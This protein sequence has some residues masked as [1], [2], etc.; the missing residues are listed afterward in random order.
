MKTGSTMTAGIALVCGPPPQRLASNPSFGIGV[1]APD[2]AD[3]ATVIIA[4]EPLNG[5]NWEEIAPGELIHV[6]RDLTI[7]REV[8]VEHDPVHMMVLGGQAAEAQGVG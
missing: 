1:S 8:I 4:S 2:T 3:Q 6:A 7:T 5:D